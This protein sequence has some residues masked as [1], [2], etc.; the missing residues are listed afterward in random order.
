MQCHHQNKP[1]MIIGHHILHGKVANLEK[2]FAVI[3]KSRQATQ[4][5]EA[6]KNN[7]DVNYY[8]IQTIIKR[9]I[10][11]NGLPKPII[12]SVPKTL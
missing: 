1:I 9:K 8:D 3:K 7:R 12:A 2:P 5:S 10:I 6:C 4:N 11:F